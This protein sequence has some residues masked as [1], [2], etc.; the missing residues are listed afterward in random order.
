M[1]TPPKKITIQGFE[2]RLFGQDAIAGYFDKRGAAR[3][4]HNSRVKIKVLKSG[5]FINAR[6]RHY[7]EKDLY[8]EANRLLL[9]GCAIYLGIEDSPFIPFGNVYDV[10]R[11]KIVWLRLLHS[12]SYKYGY[13][14]KLELAGSND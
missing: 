2:S 9:P 4:A 5:A 13:G 6:M 8:V 10:Y 14:V 3:I 11:A 7:S 1:E 12:A